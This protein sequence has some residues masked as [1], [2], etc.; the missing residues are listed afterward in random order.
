MENRPKVKTEQKTGMALTGSK[1]MV[2]Q[3]SNEG[4]KRDAERA[5]RVQKLAKLFKKSKRYINQVLAGDRVSEEII[6]AYQMFENGESIVE[7]SIR[8]TLLNQ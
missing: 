7:K 3:F 5:A 1:N 4:E 6:D 8:E 2:S